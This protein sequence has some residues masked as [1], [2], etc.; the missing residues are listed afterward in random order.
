MAFEILLEPLDG[1]QR[2][3]VGRQPDE[4][5]VLGPLHTLGHVRWGLT[6]ED[7]V[8]TL[9]IM[10]GPFVQKLPNTM[11]RQAGTQE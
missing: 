2:G 8:E 11:R 1:V 10:L 6:Q 3:T 9:G 5:D 7:K 4:D